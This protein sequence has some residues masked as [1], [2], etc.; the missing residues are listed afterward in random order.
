MNVIN[1]SCLMTNFMYEDQKNWVLLSELLAYRFFV[2]MQIL[3]L[4]FI[5]VFASA[6]LSYFGE[7][8]ET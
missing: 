1:V 3:L 6:V 8:S 2:Y 7:G 4:D 5:V